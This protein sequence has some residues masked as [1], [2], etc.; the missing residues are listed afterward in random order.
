MGKEEKKTVD[1]MPSRL[2]FQF[3]LSS[4]TMKSAFC[5]VLPMCGQY[6]QYQYLLWVYLLSA[7]GWIVNR[8]H[9]I[10]LV[11]N[12]NGIVSQQSNIRFARKFVNQII[13]VCDELLLFSQCSLTVHAK[14]FRMEIEDGNIGSRL[15]IH[16]R[17]NGF[18]IDDK[19]V[20]VSHT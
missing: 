18:F 5:Y 16:V 15:A 12:L 9:R 8:C 19:S 20:T 11:R 4:Q 6:S 14:I 7:I 2:Q 17:Q 3:L 1:D 10:W 13:V